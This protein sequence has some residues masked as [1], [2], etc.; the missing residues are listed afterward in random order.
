[1]VRRYR[2]RLPV[3]VTEPLRIGA[4]CWLG[5]NV[6]VLP[7]VTVG[8]GSVIAAGAVVTRDVPPNVLVAG[9]PARLIRKLAELEDEVMVP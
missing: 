3:S 5:A 9:V 4:G 8:P 2:H 7:G 6:T 1:M